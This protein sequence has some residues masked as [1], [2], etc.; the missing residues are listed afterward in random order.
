MPNDTPSEPGFYWAT[1]RASGRVIVEVYKPSGC[2]TL[3][4]KIPG[5]T[6]RFLLR[7]FTDWSGPIADPRG[8]DET[9]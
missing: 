5:T 6:W 8:K 7:D 9:T 2:V 4:C 3:K 1:L